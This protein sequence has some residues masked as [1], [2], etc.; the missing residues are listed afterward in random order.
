MAFGLARKKTPPE[1]T[2]GVSRIAQ[3]ACAHLGV[4]LPDD[5]GEPV[6]WK[7]QG[8]DSDPNYQSRINEEL[9]TLLSSL[10]TDEQDKQRSLNALHAEIV[11]SKGANPYRDVAYGI[12]LGIQKTEVCCKEALEYPDDERLNTIA[13]IISTTSYE[14]VNRLF[15]EETKTKGPTDPTPASRFFWD[16]PAWRTFFGKTAGVDSSF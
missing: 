6:Y 9:Q 2:E 5:G 13:Q 11:A 4:H 16:M 12:M 10:P 7:L 15:S 14:A 1:V 8:F 3:Q